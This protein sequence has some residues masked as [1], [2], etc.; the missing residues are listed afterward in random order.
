MLSLHVKFVQTYRRMD[1]RTT[2]KQYFPPPPP[3]PDLSIRGHK[4]VQENIVEKDE[5][6]QKEL[7]SPF[8]T[9]FSMQSVP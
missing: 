8:P 2:V 9:M 4:M 1:G 6:A 7:I 3:P 5:I